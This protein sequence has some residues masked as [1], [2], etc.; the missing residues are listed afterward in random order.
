MDE[1]FSMDEKGFY[2]D[3]SGIPYAHSKY[4][5]YYLQQRGLLVDYYHAFYE[6]R[7]TDPRG[8]ETL[9]RILQIEDFSEFHAEWQKWVLQMDRESDVM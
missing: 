5:A 7:K 6:N 4:I 8:T 9:R 1:L 2:D 3:A